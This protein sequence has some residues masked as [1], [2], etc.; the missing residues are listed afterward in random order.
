MQPLPVG[1]VAD[2][3]GRH[4][5]DLHVPLDDCSD[6]TGAEDVGNELFEGVGLLELVDDGVQGLGPLLEVRLVRGHHGPLSPE[7]L[8]LYIWS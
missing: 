2:T 4:P 8:K 7:I 3:R 6:L 1:G 5:T